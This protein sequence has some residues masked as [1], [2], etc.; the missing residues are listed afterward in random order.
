MN[1]ETLFKDLSN[2]FF[3]LVN[4][5][6]GLDYTSP[7]VVLTTVA[8]AILPFTA[9]Y[10]VLPAA[11]IG[12]LVSVSALFLVEKAPAGVK[13]LIHKYPFWADLIISSM[14]VAGL[15]TFLG[16]GLILGLGFIFTDV[17]LS[18]CLPYATAEAAQP[19]VIE[20]IPAQFSRG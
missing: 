12:I 10:I 9:S 19:I 1:L 7:R 4:W 16:T 18:I 13:R 2:R 3:K 6:L 15:G 8:V 11:V 14:A 17:I 20:P 5:V